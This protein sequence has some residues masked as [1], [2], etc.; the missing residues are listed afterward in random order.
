MGRQ[1]EQPLTAWDWQQKV[2]TC[3]AAAYALVED[4]KATKE[5]WSAAGR[6]VE[7]ALK[8]AIM[9]REGLNGW[10]E[11]KDRG[12]LHTHDLGSLMA[13]AG[14]DKTAIPAEL[15]GA[16]KTVLSWRREDDYRPGRMPRKVSRQM[17]ESAFADDGVIQWLRRR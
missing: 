7:F 17:V 16:W 15:R 10:P 6:A 11:K 8:A 13:L 14:I 1:T 5:A 9:R 12:E 2:E 3:R 4:K